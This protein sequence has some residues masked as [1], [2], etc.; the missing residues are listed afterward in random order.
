MS[1]VAAGRLVY[2]HG[3]PGGAGEF[4][5]LAPLGAQALTPDRNR[6][7]DPQ[8]IAREIAA[9]GEPVTLAGFSLGAFAAIRLVPLLGD[10]VRALHLISPA[11]PLQLGDFL[12]QMA[13]G[14]LF[15]LARR[16]PRLARA[17]VA[18]EAAIAGIAPRW[19]LGRL[20]ASAQGGDCELARDQA[21]VAAMSRV[22]R[23]GIGKGSTA[24][25]DELDAYVRDWRGML[26]QVRAPVTIWQGAQDNWAPPTMAEALAA[27]LPGVVGMNRLPGLSHYSTLRA[28][29]AQIAR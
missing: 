11:A 27:A 8:A 23:D 6:K 24:M 16:S 2:L 29:L 15:G 7:S 22:L 25:A 19:L 28:A 4:A 26:G 9:M 17:A 14:A 3:M 1:A 13:G 21:F 5:A 12:P 20:L 18:A 10:R